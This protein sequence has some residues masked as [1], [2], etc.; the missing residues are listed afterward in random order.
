[1][2]K[3]FYSGLMPK[4]KH[5]YVKTS[6]GT[7]TAPIP[8]FIC[9]IPHYEGAS[10]VRTRL[11]SEVVSAK[12]GVQFGSAGKQAA[13]A[14][15]RRETVGACVEMPRPTCPALSS[16]APVFRISNKSSEIL[17]CFLTGLEHLQGF[18]FQKIPS[19]LPVCS[20]NLTH[21]VFQILKLSPYKLDS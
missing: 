19:Y 14:P 2:C 20:T 6:A 5:H 18:F 16:T 15:L 8:F 21:C 3:Y 11:S 10:G 4:M 17:D 12:P 9:W 7:L 13:R 1:M